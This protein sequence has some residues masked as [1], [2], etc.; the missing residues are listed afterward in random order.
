M[1]NESAV[2]TTS[3]PK[4]DA[5]AQ[6]EHLQEE[7]FL[8]LS[9]GCHEQNWAQ[10]HAIAKQIL[11]DRRKPKED[12]NASN[13]SSD[14]L[15]H[16]DRGGTTVFSRSADGNQ[17]NGSSID[18]GEAIDVDCKYYDSNAN[19]QE[20]TPT[21]D[22]ECS[23]QIDAKNNLNCHQ[24]P[25]K[26][27]HALHSGTPRM[28]STCLGTASPLAWTCRYSAP[29]A[30]VKLV[31]DLDPS[32][33]RR[34]LPQLGTPLHEC[35]GRPRPLR[36]MPSKR[37]AWCDMIGIGNNSGGAPA[38][39]TKKKKQIHIPPILTGLREW[40]RTVRTLIRADELLMK[41]DAIPSGERH[42]S[43]RA[44]LAQDADGNT[45]LH[46]IIREAAA[47]TFSW[48]RWQP[49]E[50]DGD[51][52]ND[53]DETESE[54]DM[55][56]GAE[57]E[58][59]SNDDD[60]DGDDDSDTTIGTNSQSLRRCG[61]WGSRCTF[62]DGIR[63]CMEAHLRR[64]ERRTARQSRW[65]KKMNEFNRV[66]IDGDQGASGC[67]ASV[68]I[69]SPILYN[70][71]HGDKEMLDSENDDMKAAALS[72]SI[73]LPAKRKSSN[74][75]DEIVKSRG[76]AT[77]PIKKNVANS[78]SGR[79]K[80]KAARVKKYFDEDEFQDCKYFCPL[81]GVVRDLVNSCPEA[82][83]VPDHREYSE[84]PLIV[85][86]K[87][88]IYVV[89]EPDNEFQLVERMTGADTNFLQSMGD[90]LGGRAVGDGFAIANAQPFN[91][92]QDDGVVMA[93][94]RGHRRGVTQNIRRTFSAGLSTSASDLN[95]NATSDIINSRDER[96]EPENT[97]KNEVVGEDQCGEDYSNCSTISDDS[98][99]DEED[100]PRY[101]AF[102]DE[103]VIS[104]ELESPGVQLGITPRRRPRYDYQTALEFRIF[105][106]V[107]IMLESY[108]RAACLMISDYSP[109]H[110]AVFHGRCPDTIRL[111]LDAEARFGCNYHKPHAS[112][113][114]QSVSATPETCPTLSGPAMLCTNTRGELPIHFA[115]MRNE[116]AR[117][118]RLLAEADP[119]SAL[120]RDASGKTPLRW[121]WIRFV[122]SLLD[123]FG[124]RDTQ[125]ENN[126]VDLAF[127]EQEEGHTSN[128]PSPG[129]SVLGVIS[130]GRTL[131]LND[132]FDG[133]PSISMSANID[134]E[135]MFVFDTEYLRRIRHVDRTVDFLRMRYVP[136]G[137]VA[138]EYVAAEHAIAVLLKLKYLQQKRNRQID[139][140]NSSRGSRINCLLPPHV[141]MSTKEEFILYAF[142]KFTS[143]IRAALI[144]T[145]S[146]ERSAAM[147]IATRTQSKTNVDA[148]DDLS[149]IPSTKRLW[150]SLNRLESNKRFL[151]VHEACR[152]AANPAGVAVI[153]IKLFSDQLFQKDDDGQLPL[154]KVAC[155]GLGWE[156]LG[157]EIS[158]SD[159]ILADETLILLREVLSE[160]HKEAPNVYD[161]NK[162]LPLHCAV[163][164]LVTSLVM[165]KERRASQHPEA[166]V[167]LQKHRHTLVE[168][169]IQCLSEL[170]QANSLALQRRDGKSGLFPF[171]QAATPHSDCTIMKYASDLS[172]RPGFDIGVGYHSTESEVVE[173]DD[174]EA[175]SNHITIIYYL[176]REDPSVIQGC[177]AVSL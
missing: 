136:S 126:G 53:F 162:Q 77:D 134:S 115:C 167:A 152:S 138:I 59:G 54:G 135:T 91:I 60:S 161:R 130:Q 96:V 146:E 68:R 137:F 27:P 166:K 84:T 87:S 101:D 82:V 89:M 2:A 74:L 46:F 127:R 32:S 29:S 72:Y 110:S 1:L 14:E 129:S 3:A 56:M 18:A 100:D 66:D 107:R 108:P 139:A 116:C 117:T 174:V 41:E 42:C 145:E 38:P 20:I 79:I 150:H 132:A 160:S 105:C 40:R 34:C 37:G 168:V 10:V 21:G 28:L 94:L 55:E 67:V 58:R 78:A 9:Q 177:E 93:V 24:I 76:K 73:K 176:L 36:K 39:T 121:L 144:A 85:A 95:L 64:V 119:R 175:E 65:Q 99:F 43:S 106:L 23:S 17:T 62:W 92:F 165:G 173:E 113:E 164:S 163:D 141:P 103:V 31:L 69:N 102:A 6:A 19:D 5:D 171:M 155:R 143:L 158:A 26:P 11:L 149:E 156:P 15:E 118:I 25:P 112:Q 52:D 49:H 47:P 45:P 12:A 154:H 4:G 13:W 123:R 120:V 83:G 8:Q 159:A 81:L 48:G 51:D 71:D 57:T 63:W 90:G 142:E 122:D 157:S 133:R 114:V 50:I 88:S 109:L 86:L 128:F 30:T 131:S 7:R 140:Y 151:L 98:T 125:K 22:G 97:Q 111:L 44:T 80:R 147:D 148:E 170:L 70:N 172:R 169:A 124:G 104:L 61:Y 75:R 153:C 16:W 35:V 33:V